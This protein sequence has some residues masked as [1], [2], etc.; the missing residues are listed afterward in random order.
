VPTSP[1]DHWLTILPTATNPEHGGEFVFFPRNARAGRADR[2]AS[3]TATLASSK[4]CSAQGSRR[5]PATARHNRDQAARHFIADE[6]PLALVERLERSSSRPSDLWQVAKELASAPESWSPEQAKIKRPLSG[7]SPCAAHRLPVGDGQRLLGVT[8]RL[9]SRCGGRLRQRLP[10]DNGAWIDGLA[11]RSIPPTPLRRAP[12]SRG[13][14][15]P[16]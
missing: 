10:D 1:S 12:P 5:H 14:I 2:V 11:H 6:P 3:R 16:R 13:S 15:P 9:V 7:T 4:G 8:N